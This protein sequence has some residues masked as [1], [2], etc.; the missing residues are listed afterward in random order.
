MDRLAKAVDRNATF[1]KWAQ[2]WFADSKPRW[3]DAHAAQVWRSLEANILPHLARIPITAITAAHV[4]PIL[5]VL[6]K[7]IPDLASK[8]AQ[9]V[10]AIFDFA[11]AHGVISVNPAAASAKMVKKNKEAAAKNLPAITDVAGIG[12]FMRI[13]ARANVSHG[14]MAAH[15]IAAFTAQRISEIVPARWEEFDLDAGLWNIPRSRMKK[16]EEE[17]GDHKV[18]LPFQL[19]AMLQDWKKRGEQHVCPSPRDDSHVSREAVEKFYRV[20]IDYR[21]R[22]SPHSWRSAFST[23]A[24]DSEFDHAVIEAHLD[25]VLHNGSVAADYDR[26]KRLVARQELMRWW[27]D[28]LHSSWH[29]ADVLPLRRVV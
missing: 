17:R 6:G 25:H 1:E 4:T 3:T 15:L 22:H 26:G 27:G 10:V 14:V 13:A 29:G 8:I 21:D 11:V 18:P 20:T 5:R 12:E 24:H 9:R 7:R 16:K 23:L 2:E 28:T 19:I